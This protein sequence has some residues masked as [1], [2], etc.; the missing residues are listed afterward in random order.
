MSGAIIG[1]AADQQQ[2]ETVPEAPGGA[3]AGSV[4]QAAVTCGEAGDRREVVGEAGNGAEALEEVQRCE[5]DL[6]LLS[7]TGCFTFMKWFELLR[8]EYDCPVVM[9]HVPYQG[10]GEISD[11]MR[12]YVVEQLRDK[13]IPELERVSGAEAQRA[14]SR[15]VAPVAGGRSG[16]RRSGIAGSWLTHSSAEP[17]SWQTSRMSV[18]AVSAFSGSRLAV[19]SSAR[20]MDGVLTRARAKGAEPASSRVLLPAL[21]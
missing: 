3:L 15:R 19:G 12:Q 21:S 16:N 10:D 9:L 8:Q 7:Y 17:R 11:S 4:A 20:M 14:G 6:L 18:I 2:G 5:P 13:V 1:R